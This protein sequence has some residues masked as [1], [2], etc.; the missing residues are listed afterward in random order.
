MR[1]ATSLSAWAA[2]AFAVA[3]AAISATPSQALTMRALPAPDPVT[4]AA[5][6]CHVAIMSPNL[7]INSGYGRPVAPTGISWALETSAPFFTT[8][9]LAATPCLAPLTIWNS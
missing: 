4:T 9:T 8:W 6:S 2:T 3:L 1:A 7:V 5:D